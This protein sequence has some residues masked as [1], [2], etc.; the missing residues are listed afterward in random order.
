MQKEGFEFGVTTADGK[1]LPVALVTTTVDHGLIKT[2]DFGVLKL[3]GGN[4]QLIVRILATESQIKKLR[5][6]QSAGSKKVPA[7]PNK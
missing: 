6:F 7:P 4:G 2:E 3:L 5:E 1:E